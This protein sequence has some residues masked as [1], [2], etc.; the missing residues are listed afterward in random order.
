[1]RMAAQYLVLSD[2]IIIFHGIIERSRGFFKCTPSLDSLFLDLGNCCIKSEQ[3]Q[4]RIKLGVR[5]SNAELYR[6]V[7]SAL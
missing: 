7:A 4:G 5:V 3:I 6:T 1:M 2:R